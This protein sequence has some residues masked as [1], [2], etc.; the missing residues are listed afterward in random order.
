[1]NR[2]KMMTSVA[3][4]LTSA[5]AIHPGTA[6][7]ESRMPDSS[8]PPVPPVATKIP[9]RTEQLGRVRVDDY[10]WMKDDNWQKVLRD[11]AL[12]KPEVKDHLTAENA[13]VKAMLAST[14]VL[15][16]AMFE[17]MKGRIKEDDASVPAPDGPFEYYSRFNIGGQHPIFARRPKGESDGEEVLLDCD[18]LAKGKAYSQVSAADH[19]PDHKLFAYAEDAQGSEVHNIYVKDLATGEILKEPVES[20]TGDFAWSP[21]SAWLFWTHRDD[22][23]RSDKIYR[24]PARGGLKDDVLVYDEPDDGFFVSVGTTGSDAFILISAGDHETSETLLIPA[25][26]PTAAPTVVEPRTVGLRYSVEH[27]DGRFVI[28]TNAD[29][30]IDFKLVEAP[31]ATPG[32]AHWKDFVAHKPGHFI[33]GLAAYKN[34]LVRVERVNANT[35]IVI[36]DRASKAEHP[37][38]ID[39]EAY[40]LSL[41][42]GY[43][44]DTPVMRYV[45]QS[46]TTPRQ[47]FDYDMATGAKTLRKTQEIPSGHDSAAYVTKRL[48]A[49][50]ADGQD[51][52]ITVLMKKGV[53]LDGT[54]PLLLYGY[55]SYG[56]SMDPSFSIRNLSLV[57]RGWIWATA[58][59]RGGSEKGYGWFLDGRKFTKKNTFTDF[60]A[61]AEHLHG[62]GYGAKDRTV[63]Y[64]G[65]AGGMLMGAIT[66]LRPDLWSGII[67]AVPFVDVLNTMSDT[68]LP[69]TP[70]EWPEWGNP[71]EDPE[72]YDYIASY[73]PYDNVTAKAYPAV[74]ATGGLSDPRV[75]YWEPEKWTAKLREHTT[76]GAPIL[77]KINMEAG[78]GGASGRFDFL[79]EIA[80]DYAFAVW[81]VE[82][83][84]AKA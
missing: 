78:H 32:R 10:A 18:A 80:L 55:G 75:T 58:H 25:A 29:G 8:K 30:A 35:R 26:D 68:S 79:K 71:L 63:A 16:T 48:Y 27:W 37:I 31:V 15:Q 81:A 22:N 39:E 72:A 57:D 6:Q 67:G 50:A 82:K 40:V 7:S 52:P 73:S 17:E 28:L 23:G 59:I 45:Y 1:V 65:S 42:G 60:I 49:K 24:R 46:P 83:G 47:W 19:S 2:R 69:L 38:V 44:F 84:W 14:E 54:A 3:A 21:D 61:C 9:L 62:A 64:G 20:S 43:E 76:S 5:S 34:H 53:A 77:L 41:E 12:I 36:T 11:P 56:M 4:M 74:L 13:Y 33:T 51:V 70:P 66:N